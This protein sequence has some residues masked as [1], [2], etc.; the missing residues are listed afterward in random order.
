MSS[1]GP[2]SASVIER[3]PWDVKQKNLRD[4]YPIE[5]EVSKDWFKNAYGMYRWHLIRSAY[6]RDVIGEDFVTDLYQDWRDTTE[7]FKIDGENILGEYAGV[8]AFVKAAKRGNDVYK[9][10][11]RKKFSFFDELPPIDFFDDSWGHKTTPMLFITLTI[12]QKRYSIKEAYDVISQEFNRFETLLRQKF[13]NFVHF[14]V[15]EAHES[16]YPHVH[17]IYYFLKRSFEVWEHW[18]DPGDESGIKQTWRVSNKV[19]DSIKQMWSM[20]WN[21]DI[22]GVR[23]TLGAFSEV[24][25]YVTK[26]I[27]SSKANKTNAMLTLF[28]KQS[29][30]ISSKNPF[31]QPFPA[32]QSFPESLID[33]TPAT[34]I[35]M[36]QV[37]ERDMLKNQYLGSMVNVWASYDFIGAIWGV[38]WYLRFYDALRLKN[39]T[40]VEPGLSALVTET[41]HNYNIEFP[42]IVSWRFV[43]FVLG[44]D[45]EP[46]FGDL[47]KSWCFVVKDPPPEVDLCVNLSDVY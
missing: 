47:A 12:D 25:K 44:S 4:K 45:L 1:Y 26:S 3:Y 15:W 23:D 40:L 36:K 35:S 33:D 11:I 7:F 9:D 20:G 5:V 38:D 17:V 43:G 39:E 24:K 21:L 8:S 14:R 10:R 37:L 46:I 22:Q 31:T 16:G 2:R 28:R 34:D 18:N 29:Y 30:H 19:R 32:T 41:M 13:G 27:W 42:E 6:D